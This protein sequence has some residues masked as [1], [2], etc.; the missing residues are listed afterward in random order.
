MHRFD[1]G[2][3]GASC[4]GFLHSASAGL[5]GLEVM[6]EKIGMTEGDL[7]AFEPDGDGFA[8]A[9][10]VALLASQG[11]A[12]EVLCEFLVNLPAW[13]YSCGAIGQSLREHFDWPPEATA[14]VDGF[15][16]RSSFEE[17][18]LAVIQAGLDGGERP[19]PMARAARHMQ[20]Y[21]MLFWD[22][23][24]TRAGLA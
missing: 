17:Q 11:T 15:A 19:Q 13:G 1:D 24:A 22:A 21:E 7:N 4:R 18:A 6:A 10:Y 9:A 12:A 5:A 3:A 2:V 23:V 16:L 20:R 14:F 8:Y